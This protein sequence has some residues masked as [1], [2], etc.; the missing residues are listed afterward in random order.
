MLVE[1]PSYA[2]VIGRLTRLL[3]SD[4]LLV[5]VE[6]ELSFVSHCCALRQ[7]FQVSIN[8]TP[9]PSVAKWSAGVRRAVA[10]TTVSPLSTDGSASSSDTPDASKLDAVIAPTGR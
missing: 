5:L 8:G 4:G 2:D 3:K 6:P 9:A 10:Q 7:L 1:V